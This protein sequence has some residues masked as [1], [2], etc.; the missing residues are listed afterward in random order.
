MTRV[1]DLDQ[2][3]WMKIVQLSKYVRG[4]KDIPLI[5]SADKS[6]ILNLHIYGSYALHPNTRGHTGGGLTTG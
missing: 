3:Y 4:T 6:G 2:R 1:T 5:L